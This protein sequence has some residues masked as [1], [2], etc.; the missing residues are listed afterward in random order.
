MDS[1]SSFI[2]NGVNISEYYIKDK[3]AIEATLNAH[4][5]VVKQVLEDKSIIYPIY[6]SKDVTFAEEGVDE[7]RK[8]L[9]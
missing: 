8:G 3:N 5:A 9:L 4:R 6:G 2:V 7:I 1:S